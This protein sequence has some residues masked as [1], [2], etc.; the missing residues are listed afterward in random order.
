[1][2]LPQVTRA[3]TS[4]RLS[5]VATTATVRDPVS[6]NAPS[7]CARTLVPESTAFAVQFVRHAALFYLISHHV[8]RAQEEPCGVLHAGDVDLLALVVAVRA[9]SVPGCP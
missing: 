8:N 6:T 2:L 3:R 9:R 1:M 7:T 4:R 5:P